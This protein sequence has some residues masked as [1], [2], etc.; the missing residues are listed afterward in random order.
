[1]IKK[2][3]KHKYN[4]SGNRKRFKTEV[5]KNNN[6]GKSYMVHTHHETQKIKMVEQSLILT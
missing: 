1:M 6:F 5:N 3:S 2:R 4:C